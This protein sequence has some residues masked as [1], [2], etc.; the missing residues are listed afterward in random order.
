MTWRILLAV[1]LAAAPLGAQLKQF[2]RLV[3]EFTLPMGCT[4][5]LWS[6]TKRPS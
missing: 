3:T 4:S 1:I 5:S 6:V 2:E